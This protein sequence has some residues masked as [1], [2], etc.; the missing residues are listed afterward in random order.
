M[1]P[2]LQFSFFLTA[3]LSN[4]AKWKC[5]RRK[6]KV[7]I[8]TLCEPFFFLN[9]KHKKTTPKVKLQTPPKMF[10][11]PLE[12]YLIRALKILLPPEWIQQ[13]ACFYQTASIKHKR[14][15]HQRGSS[16]WTSSAT[17]I[18]RGKE[19]K[20]ENWNYMKEKRRK[21]I[22]VSRGWDGK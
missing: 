6:A 7:F 2:A 14:W 5:N 22:R 9:V 17:Q 13:A 16:W 21:E 11:S 20:R 18:Q 4:F 19:G 15:R 8:V 10:Y 12:F 1:F 3:L